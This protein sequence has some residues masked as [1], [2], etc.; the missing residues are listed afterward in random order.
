MCYLYR[1][2]E[3][4]I[5]F[6][7]SNN[8]SWFESI[9]NHE[10]FVAVKHLHSALEIHFLSRSRVSATYTDRAMFETLYAFCTFVIWIT[11]KRKEYDMIR[12]EIGR[13]EVLGSL[14]QC[15]SFRDRFSIL[16]LPTSP[17]FLYLRK[18]WH[19]VLLLFFEIFCPHRNCGF[20]F[21]IC[22]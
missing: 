5:S 21:A 18:V 15:L 12:E 3:L 10:H 4:K 22:W 11:F 2:N 8:P 20:T 6:V 13:W 9:R 7:I 1:M 14:L 17:E 16:G 19:A